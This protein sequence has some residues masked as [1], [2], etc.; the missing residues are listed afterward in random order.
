[1]KRSLPQRRLFCW[2]KKEAGSNV[3]RSRLNAIFHNYLFIVHEFFNL[4]K[5]DR[6][7]GILSFD[8]FV[9]DLQ[10]FSL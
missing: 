10:C 6:N 8:L 1:M 4:F 3:R 5:S 7:M 9:T 2:Q